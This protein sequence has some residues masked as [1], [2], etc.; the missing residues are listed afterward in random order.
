M[1]VF[2][3]LFFVLKDVDQWQ[4]N[5]LFRLLSAILLFVGGV[6]Q[7]LLLSKDKVEPLDERTQL[8]QY[9]TSSVSVIGILLYVYALVMTL[10]IS[11]EFEVGLPVA[12][13]WFIAYT[14][15]FVAFMLHS[16]LY[17]LFEHK[18]VGYED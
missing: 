4:E 2:I 10:Y 6:I 14:T 1:T 11:Y 9:R 12:W 8:I 15:I 7:I 18:G 5:Q 17:L 3:V 13:L 16:G